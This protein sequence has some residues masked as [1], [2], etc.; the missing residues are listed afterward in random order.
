MV[1]P[2][3]STEFVPQTIADLSYGILFVLAIS[4]LSVYSLILAG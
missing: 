3:I 4:S 1:L 2:F